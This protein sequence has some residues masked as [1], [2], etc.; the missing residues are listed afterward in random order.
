MLKHHILPSPFSLHFASLG[1]KLYVAASIGPYGATLGDFS[2]Y[3]GRYADTM[4]EEV[5]TSNIFM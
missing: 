2:E 3:H 5:K 4:S 1:Q